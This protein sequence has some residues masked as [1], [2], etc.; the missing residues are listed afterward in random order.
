MLS[1]TSSTLLALATLTLP[2]LASAASITDII[3]LASSVLNAL[4]GL[5]ITAAIVV[6]FWGLVTYM[7]SHAADKKSEGLTIAMYGVLTIFIMVSIW[8]IIKLLQS[9]F[10]VTDTSPVI[11][12]GIVITPTAH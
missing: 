6:F 5:L 4:I 9:T 1:R 7:F 11:P 8:G 10:S 2:M 3:V 12:R